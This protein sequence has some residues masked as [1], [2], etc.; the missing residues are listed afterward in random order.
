MIQPVRRATRVVD[1]IARRILIPRDAPQ[2]ERETLLAIA[3]KRLRGVAC[4][5]NG[6]AVRQ[7]AEEMRGGS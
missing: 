5:L 7:L 1:L 2:E 6:A 4:R 3:E